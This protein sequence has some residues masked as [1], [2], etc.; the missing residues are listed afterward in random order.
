MCSNYKNQY[1]HHSFYNCII[2]EGILEIKTLE[3]HH[4]FNSF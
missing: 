1:G 3:L 4:H 2:I